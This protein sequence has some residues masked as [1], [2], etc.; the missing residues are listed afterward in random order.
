M[1][2]SEGGGTIVVACKPAMRGPLSDGGGADGCGRFHGIYRMDAAGA[3]FGFKKYLTKN[4]TNGPS[5]HGRAFR[6][7]TEA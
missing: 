3:A 4:K 1:V 2:L 6:V 5:G 7:V